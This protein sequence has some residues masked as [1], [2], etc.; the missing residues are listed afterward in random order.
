[1]D[2][3]EVKF[4]N[5]GYI[6]YERGTFSVKVVFN[7]V[8]GWTMGRPGNFWAMVRDRSAARFSKS[9]SYFRPKTVFFHTR[10]QT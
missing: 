7:W 8:R 9:L 1:M 10:F 5:G 3:E 2:V 4:F 6:L